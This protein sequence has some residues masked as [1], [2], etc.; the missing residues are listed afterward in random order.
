M[1]SITNKIGDSISWK[2]KYLQS[3][4]ITPVDL[5]G[6]S[7]DVD[8]YHKVNKELLFNLDTSSSTLSRYITTDLLN[9]GEFTIVIKDTGA[10]PQG[11]Y[12]VDIEYTDTDGFRKSS[13]SFGLKV[14]ER[15]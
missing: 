6:F 5:T 12:L 7:I 10:F 11:D 15:L 2:I 13:K 9:I 1:A 8:A 14:V 3:D 4:N